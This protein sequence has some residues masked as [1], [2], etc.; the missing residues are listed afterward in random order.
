[1]APLGNTFGAGLWNC[2]LVCCVSYSLLLMYHNEDTIT[3]GIWK[4]ELAATN[5]KMSYIPV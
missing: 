1:M 5:Q 4:V 3:A 2:E